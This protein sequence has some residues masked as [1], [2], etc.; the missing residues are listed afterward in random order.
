MDPIELQFIAPLLV[1]MEALDI[2][3]D[4]VSFEEAALKLIS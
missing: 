4:Y 2:R 3:L 1:E